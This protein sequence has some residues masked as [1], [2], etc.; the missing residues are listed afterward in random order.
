MPEGS[1]K[2]VSVIEFVKNL[3]QE[4]MGLDEAGEIEIRRAHRTPTTIRKDGSKLRPIHVYLLRYSDKHYILANAAK[5]L[6][7]NQ[8]EGSTIFISDDVTKEVREH[9][10]KLKEKYLD[11]LRKR[12]EVEFVYVAWSVPAKILYKV[13]GEQA[14]RVIQ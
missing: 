10:K 6:K 5:C 7:D 1:E 13:K 4:H 14:L 12:D 2:D 8:Y 9:R 11:D 3:L